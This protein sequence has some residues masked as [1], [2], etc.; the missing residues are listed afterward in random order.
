MCKRMPIRLIYF[1]IV[2]ASLPGTLSAEPVEVY[3]RQVKPILEERCFACHGALKQEGGLRLDTADLI[4]TGGDSG[5]AVVAGDSQQ[6]LLMERISAEVEADRMPPEGEPLKV[7]EIA[8]ISAWIS[9]GAIAPADEQPEQDPAAHW[10]FQSPV[11]PNVPDIDDPAWNKNPIDAFLAAEHAQHNL[12]PQP[13]L[14]RRLWLRRVTLDLIGLPPTPAETEAF[15]ADESES[16]YETVVDRLL[17]SPHYGERWGR[18][19]MDIWRYSDPWGLGQDIRNSQPHLWHWRDWIV[20]SLN[21]DKSYLQMLR[22]MLA[23]DELYPNDLGRLRASGYLARQ[24][25]KF[26]RT[27]WLDE[28]VEHTTKGML[29]LTFNCAKCHDHKYDPISHE[30]YY[31]MRAIF[32]PYQVRTDL[33]PGEPDATK[34]GIVRAFDNNL[35]EP[36]YLHIRGDDRN[37]DTSRPIAPGLPDVLPRESFRIEPIELPLEAHQPGLREHIVETL[38]TRSSQR[39]QSAQERLSNLENSE[40]PS[41]EKE[42]DLAQAELADALAEKESIEKRVAADR[43]KYHAD[44]SQED[45][46]SVIQAAITTESRAKVTAARRLVAQRAW[47]KSQADESKQ[48]VATARLEEAEKALGQ[49]E[50]ALESPG[51]SY[52][53]LVGSIKTPESNIETAESQGRPFPET[54]TGRRKALADWIADSTNPLTARVAVNH[55]WLRHFG[56]PLVPTVFDFGRKGTP[57]THP[58]L[59]DYLAIELV[60]HDGSMKHLHRLMVTSQAYRLQS[61]QLAADPDTLAA[62]P[63]NR[64]YWRTNPIRMESQVVRDS[65]LHLAGELDLT[66]G[67]PSI[68]ISQEDSRRRA[69]YFVH[70][71]NDNERFL[72]MF[73]DA[74]VL[75]CY[76]R[77][78][79]IVPQQALALENS[80]L[81]IEMSEEIAQ[82]IEAAHPGMDD[83]EFIREAFQQVL[84]SAPTAE[85]Q[86]IAEQALQ[87]LIPSTTDPAPVRARALFILALLNHNDFVTIR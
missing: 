51:D 45:S 74:N 46:Q 75:D 36:T 16:A 3:L 35:A 20:E 8:A 17:A 72:S 69:L 23:A 78:D 83:A 55:I 67:G 32:E 44:E 12:K 86:S 43:V 33:V 54:S 30:D 6:S 40:P 58:E 26:N 11:R 62:D 19:W 4:Q 80:K 22:E 65:L 71:K 7:D 42:L 5:A 2:S 53:S 10:A 27:S 31:A 24:Y 13:P 76:R 84:A 15:L 25:F 9:S 82:R 1:V 77:S 14:D 66:L 79:S 52:T 70:S 41:A 87:A 56:Q 48:K 34:D 38:L 49:A 21:E 63:E 57:P 37:P 60:E 50:A 18:H 81:A 28:T 59:L 73:D 47:E 85:E 68:P 29:G 39:I 64:W 61:S